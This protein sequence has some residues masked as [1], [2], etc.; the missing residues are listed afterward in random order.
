MR[1]FVY[2]SSTARTSGNFDINDLMK[3]GRMDIVMH[4]IINAF[5][6]SHQLRD[7]V[8]LHMIFYGAPDPPK[9]IEMRVRSKKGVPETGSKVESLDI[10]KKDVG[11]LIKKILYKYKKGEK[12]EVFPGC[13]IEKKS[14]L[15]VIDEL[16]REGK[17]IILLDK[18]GE[19]LRETK[20]S[21]KSVFVMGD[22][23]GLPK[24]ELKRLRKIAKSV[25]VGP[26]I[27]F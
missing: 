16:M 9:H 11:N 1:T 17:E 6:L 18:K 13:F 23:L 8:L 12:T 4:V 20:I 27:Y 25:S 14:F 2:F 3:S 10:S 7:D 5:F 26:R 24:K 19:K 22:H 15:S 21:E